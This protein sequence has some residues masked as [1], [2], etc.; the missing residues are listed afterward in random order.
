MLTTLGLAFLA[1]I[2]SV[3]S[4]CVLPLLPLVLG[5]AAGEHR[6]GPAVL[7]AGLAISFVAI[8]LFVATI[9]FSLGLDTD[10]FRFAA[11]VLMMLV[12][13][14]LILPALQTRLTSALGPLSDWTER[15]FGGFSKAGLLGQFGLGLLLGAV[16]SPCVGPTLGA[17]SLLA[18]QSRDL[19]GVAATMLVFGLGS[20]LPL[21][22]AGTLSREVLMRRRDGMMRLGKGLKVGL[23]VVLVV[24]G[25]TIV[26]GTDKAIEAALVDASPDWLT[27]LSTRF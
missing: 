13:L 1:G 22:V 5:A 21:L 18:S 16:W 15:R 17:A 10:V 24:I 3:L 9:G 2:L 4:P 6:Y 20:A 14:V 7:A 12:G 23:G 8:G 25:L 26:S 11:A 19:G 27:R